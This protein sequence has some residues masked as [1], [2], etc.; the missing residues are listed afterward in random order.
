MIMCVLWQINNKCED[1]SEYKVSLHYVSYVAN[2][3]ILLFSVYVFLYVAGFA[4]C[5]W[6]HCSSVSISVSSA[7]EVYLYTTMRYIYRRFTYLLTYSIAFK[8]GT[9]FCHITGDTLQMFKVKGQGQG[10]MVRGKGH[11]VK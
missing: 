8:F 4:F 6:K 5:H 3:L 7:L 1:R 2:T 9:E 10:H 11:S